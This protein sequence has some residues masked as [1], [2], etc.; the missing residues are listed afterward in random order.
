MISKIG[1]KHF[2]CFDSVQIPLKP[3]TLLSGSNASG[4][5]SLLQSLVLLNQTMIEHEWYNRLMLNG[6]SLC[7]GT[8]SDIVDKINGRSSIEIE[9]SSSEKVFKWTLSGERGD[10]SMGIDTVSINGNF[11]NNPSL[12]QHLVP[13]DEKDSVVVK[14]LRNLTYL[15]A[16][17]IGPKEFY[18]LEDKINTQ[19]VG[20]TGEYTVSLLHSGRDEHILDELVCNNVANT[21][22]RQV[23]ARM[24][25]FFPNCGLIIEQIPKVNA[26]TLGLRTSE[27]TDFH[28]PVHVGFGL[29]QVLPIIVASLSA[30]KDDLLLFENPEVH[31]HPSAQVLMGQF[32]AEVANAGVQVIIETH[33]DHILNG[34][35][36]AVKNGKIE[37]DNVSFN[38]FKPRNIDSQ[39]I[40][41]PQIDK[42]GNIDFWP[43]GFFDQFDKDMNYFAGWEL[44]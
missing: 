31:L 42:E 23:E 19:V 14:T 40:E 37:H 2:K 22:L 25:Q 6:D 12:L 3:L 18:L 43:N 30:K 15:K 26:V 17:R 16:E 21:R 7:L 13:P 4:K 10:M 39:Q 38:F 11:F 44:D 33:S 1:L 27:D 9:I 8:V 28:R 32:L 41:S 29:T 36:R 35:R 24:Q 20:P 5:S 34:I